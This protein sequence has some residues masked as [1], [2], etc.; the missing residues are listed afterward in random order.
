M[1][2]QGDVVD[3]KKKNVVKLCPTILIEIIMQVIGE[4]GTE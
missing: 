1:F 3:F 4:K 2:I